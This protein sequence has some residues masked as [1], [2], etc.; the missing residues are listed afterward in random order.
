MTSHDSSAAAAVVAPDAVARELR[1]ALGVDLVA[2]MIRVEPEL[3]AQWATGGQTPSAQDEQ[4]LRAV[5]EIYKTLAEPQTPKLAR[6]RLIGLNPNFE[7]QQPAEV[8]A[9][10]QMSDVLIEAENYVNA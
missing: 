7:G 4:T 6:A 1:E 3:V 8:F 2:R 5:F 10:G 9:A